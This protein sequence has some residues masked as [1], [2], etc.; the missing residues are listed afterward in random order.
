M[1]KWQAYH[2]MSS[3]GTCEIRRFLD[4]L[5]FNHC[6]KVLAWITMLENEGPSFTKKDS[7]VPQSE[8]AKAKKCRDD[9]I[10]HFKTLKD[11]LKNTE[12]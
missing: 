2:Y 4:G 6:Q 8:I 10:R 11:F 3:D 9:F 7:A 12:G 5:P 1:S